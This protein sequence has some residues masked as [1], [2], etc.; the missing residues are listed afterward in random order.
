MQ[1]HIFFPKCYG[2]IKIKEGVDSVHVAHYEQYEHNL[3]GVAVCSL[4]IVIVLAA[5]PLASVDGV[6]RSASQPPARLV[7]GERRSATV[8]CPQQLAIIAAGGT[9]GPPD[10]SNKIYGYAT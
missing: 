10:N 5:A 8:V 7:L 3:Y 6:D 9:I 4:F 1:H 2:M